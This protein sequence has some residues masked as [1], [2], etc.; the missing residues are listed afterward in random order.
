TDMLSRISGD[1]FLLLLSPIEGEGE[2]AEYIRLTQQ[3][4][5]AP[6]F[7]DGSEIFASTSIGVSLYPDHG[8]SYDVLCQ[9]ADIAMY[10]VKS[11]GKGAVAFFNASME[12][13]AQARMRI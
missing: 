6:F 10:R 13:E 3:R 8:S 1:E 7:I 9:N 5:T 12:R 11:D 4:L 2:V